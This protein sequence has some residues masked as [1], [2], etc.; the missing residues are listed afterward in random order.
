MFVETFYPVSITSCDTVRKNVPILTGCEKPHSRQII[1]WKNITWSCDCNKLNITVLSLVSTQ[2]TKFS[3]IYALFENLQCIIVSLVIL[4][5]F[6]I[7]NIWMG[8]KVQ[9]DY[10]GIIKLEWGMAKCSNILN[11]FESILI[12]NFNTFTNLFW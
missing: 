12:F 2:Q 11:Y 10:I 9:N 8:H 4:W 1:Y 3:V 5:L 7:F 6:W